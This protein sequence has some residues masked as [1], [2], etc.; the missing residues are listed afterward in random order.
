VLPAVLL[1][2]CRCCCFCCCLFVSPMS[3][4]PWHH[5]AT[6]ALSCEYN[7]LRKLQPGTDCSSLCS[8]CVKC[9]VQYHG[10][11]LIRQVQLTHSIVQKCPASSPLHQALPR[12]TCVYN[13]ACLVSLLRPLHL[14]CLANLQW[15]VRHHFKPLRHR[16]PEALR[17]LLGSPHCAPCPPRRPLSNPI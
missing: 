10:H 3:T 5:C 14:P 11:W 13:T 4:T 2:L 17:K 8:Q 1:L 16:L 7:A 15:L 6:A 9:N 12:M